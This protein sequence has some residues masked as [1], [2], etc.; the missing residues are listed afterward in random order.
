M[1]PTEADILAAM[2]ALHFDR[3]PPH[4]GMA[5]AWSEIPALTKRAL[6]VDAMAALALAETPATEM[7]TG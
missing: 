1:M 6:R 2:K 4:S 5:M 7:V 3:N